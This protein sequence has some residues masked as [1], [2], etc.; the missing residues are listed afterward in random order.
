[1]SMR[2]AAAAR[3]SSSGTSGVS[4]RAARPSPPSC[5]T[6]SSQLGG[7]AVSSAAGGRALA[8][9]APCAPAA[10]GD[11]CPWLGAARGE[12]A[13]GEAAGG[14]GRGGAGVLG[15]SR[16]VPWVDPA[17]TSESVALRGRP[18]ASRPRARGRGSR[19]SRALVAAGEREGGVVARDPRRVQAHLR[20]R[21]ARRPVA[22]RRGAPEADLEVKLARAA[23]E[24]LG[25]HAR[26]ERG[27]RR[28]EAEVPRGASER[29]GLEQHEPHA[30]RLRAGRRLRRASGAPRAAGRLRL[31]EPPAL[32]RRALLRRRPPA[33]F[34]FLAAS[35]RAARRGAGRAGRTSVR[36]RRR[37]G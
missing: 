4:G 26:R 23:R 20:P 36:G 24:R 7:D 33:E 27:R 32:T 17:S 10:A 22:A 2:A 11:A 29:A 34:A 21:A 14:G 31:V 6:H 8:P 16:K 5:A 9:G 25:A 13:R 28:A 3:S 12:A 37:R 35:A 15:R 18:S 19:D 1:M 30:A